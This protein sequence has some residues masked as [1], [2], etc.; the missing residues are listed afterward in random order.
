MMHRDSEVLEW[1]CPTLTSKN[2]GILLL[3]LMRQ[4]ETK[5]LAFMEINF[6]PLELLKST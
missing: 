3:L 2:S 4:P 6:Q 5:Y 1:I